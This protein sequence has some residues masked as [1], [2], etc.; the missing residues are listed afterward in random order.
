MGVRNHPGYF[1]GV[2]LCCSC[3]SVIHKITFHP[4]RNQRNAATTP[5]HGSCR[6]VDQ[7]VTPM[8]LNAVACGVS[9]KQFESNLKPRIM[10]FSVSI[11]FIPAAADTIESRFVHWRNRSIAAIM[12]VNS[13]ETDDILHCLRPIKA[14]VSAVTNSR[15]L[16]NSCQR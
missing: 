10:N 9:P 11:G 7:P 12:A 1:W 4:C 2:R 15:P 14:S 3:C 16:R 13:A 8:R 6:Q 5:R